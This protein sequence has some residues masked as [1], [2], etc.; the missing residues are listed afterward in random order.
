MD[1]HVP[2]PTTA[3]EHVAVKQVGKVRGCI[4]SWHGQSFWQF[5]NED[6]DE[7]DPFAEVGAV[8]L[9]YEYCTSC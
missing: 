6:M 7:T 5:G 4:V 9:P 2:V 1:V 3:M 8:G